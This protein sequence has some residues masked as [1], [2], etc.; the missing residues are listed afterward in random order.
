MCLYVFVYILDFIIFF[1]VFFFFHFSFPLTPS[2]LGRAD[3]PHTCY[4]QE[5]PRERRGTL[6]PLV[7][8]HRLCESHLAPQEHLSSALSWPFHPASSLLRLLFPTPRH[9]SFPLLLPLLILVRFPLRPP[10]CLRSFSRSAL[11]TPTPI[12]LFFI[13]TSPLSSSSPRVDELKCC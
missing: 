1:R 13:I 10:A 9:S 3:T 4:T 11:I 2:H 5:A 6:A 8:L 7:P 12:P